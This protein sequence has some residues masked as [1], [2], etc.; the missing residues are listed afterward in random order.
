MAARKHREIRSHSSRVK[1]PLVHLSASWFLVSTYLIWILGVRIDSVEQPINS[2]S[3]ASRHVSHLFGLLPFMIILITASLSSKAYNW[4][5]AMR[6]I[7]VC[8]D[9]VHMRQ[10]IN[11]SVSLF[12]WVW[13]CDSANSFLLL[14]WLVF[15][16]CSMNVTRLSSHT[17]NRVQH[18]TK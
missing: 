15:G 2:N 7:C 3:V 14:G 12:V 17:I 6:R 5:L 18:P 1:L 10:L 8:G 4:G 13:N 9:V 16:Y 11:I